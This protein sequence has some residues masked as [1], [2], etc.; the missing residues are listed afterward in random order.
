MHNPWRHVQ[1]IE[2]ESAEELDI[3]FSAAAESESEL[4][5]IN[6]VVLAD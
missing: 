2:G 5:L 1:N 4:L 3:I 6:E